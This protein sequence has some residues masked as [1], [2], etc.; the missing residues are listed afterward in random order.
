MDLII[1]LVS[2]MLLAS[3]VTFFWLSILDGRRSAAAATEHG[4][5]IAL[6]DL[7]GAHYPLFPRTIRQT[8]LD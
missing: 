3:S 6:Q 5:A 2:V 7:V 1:G 4:P 8:P